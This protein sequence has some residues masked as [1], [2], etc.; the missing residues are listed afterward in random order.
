MREF[1]DLTDSAIPFPGHFCYC[2]CNGKKN[3]G[4]YLSICVTN[5]EKDFTISGFDQGLLQ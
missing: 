5:G 2:F 4:S 3:E 1:Q